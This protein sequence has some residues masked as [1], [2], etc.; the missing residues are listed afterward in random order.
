MALVTMTTSTSGQE[1]TMK[2]TITTLIRASVRAAVAEVANALLKTIVVLSAGTMIDMRKIR[3]P[4]KISLPIVKILAETVKTIVKVKVVRPLTIV[5][6]V[7]VEATVHCK[8]V[9]MLTSRV[10]MKEEIGDKDS[11][12]LV[13][14][15]KSGKSSLMTMIAATGKSFTTI[16]VARWTST[17]K[18]TNHTDRVTSTMVADKDVAITVVVAKTTG[19]LPKFSQTMAINRTDSVMKRRTMTTTTVGSVLVVEAVVAVVEVSLRVT[20]R[21]L[22]KAT[23]TSTKASLTE[24]TSILTSLNSRSSTSAP[25]NAV[26][27]SGPSAQSRTWAE[28]REVRVL[29][30][31]KLRTASVVLLTRTRSEVAARIESKILVTS[32]PR[33]ANRLK[34]SRSRGSS[35]EVKRTIRKPSKLR[36]LGAK[37]VATM[38]PRRSS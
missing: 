5:E 22:T 15:V 14:T 26:R 12:T 38:R 24:L 19:E 36:T 3:T 17:M 13:V 18:M 29:A 2:S 10:N 9:A 25:N 7:D 33:S 28:A 21:G 8:M 31:L 34:T 6:T 32:M 30:T 11:K 1:I 37:M 23:S 35:V 20:Q 16:K 4:L 27:V